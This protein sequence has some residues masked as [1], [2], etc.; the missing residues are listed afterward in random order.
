MMERTLCIFKPDLVAQPAHDIGH[1]LHRLLG[2]SLMPVQLQRLTM[3]PAQ[4][5]RLYAASVGQ[6][7][8]G[9]NIAFMTS[10][11]CLVMVLEGER[12]VER[13]REIVG[14]TDPERAQQ[15]T[16]RSIFGTELPRNA[17][18]AT[19]TQA[20]VEDEIAIFFGRE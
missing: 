17:F 10:G 2:I 9:R 13:L 1:A 6:S 16:L 12:A 5:M 4:A 20:E 11:P 18:H 14:S 19:A 15:G 7:Y 3:T 8:Y